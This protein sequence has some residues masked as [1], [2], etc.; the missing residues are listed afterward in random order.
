[1]PTKQDVMNYTTE[2]LG[3]EL[4]TKTRTDG[5]EWTAEM[6]IPL[7]RLENLGQQ[8][9]I[10]ISGKRSRLHFYPKTRAV[11]WTPNAS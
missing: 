8:I 9:F 5:H 1:M 4:K 6:R 11:N 2:N 3:L 10:D 7:S